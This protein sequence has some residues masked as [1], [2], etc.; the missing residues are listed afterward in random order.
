[1]LWEVYMLQEV[2]LKVKMP[3]NSGNVIWRVYL[4]QEVLLKVKMSRKSG[5][6]IW[7]VYLLQNSIEEKSHHCEFVDFHIPSLCIEKGLRETTDS[8]PQ[9]K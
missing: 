6:V 7:R 3:W 2:L 4:L 8:A 1:V 5:N 9:E